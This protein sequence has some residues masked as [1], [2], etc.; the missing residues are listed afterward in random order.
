M[1]ILSR[2]PFFAVI[3]LFAAAASGQN[4]PPGLTLPASAS[5]GPPTYPCSRTDLRKAP[6]PDVIPSVGNLSGVNT[7]VTD[8][9]FQNPIVRVTDAY[10][11]PHSRNITFYSSAG[12]SSNANTWNKDSSLLFV[13]DTNGTGY[14]M[15]FD[16]SQMQVA[17]MY[18]ANFPKTGGMTVSSNHF[19]WSRVNP[20][21]LYVLGGTR[22][23]RY[24]FS[25]RNVP[26]SPQLIYDFAAS[27]HCLPAGFK[28]AW[29]N[30]GGVSANDGAFAFGLSSQGLQGTGN[31]AVVYTVGQGCTVLNTLTGDITS[32]WG[33]SGTMSTT[34]RFTLHDAYL[35]LDSGWAILGPTHCLSGK[36]ANGPY[37]WEV[38]TTNVTACGAGQQ[39]L[40]SGHW[41]LGY[42]HWANNDGDPFGQFHLRPF[43]NLNAFTPLINVLPLGFAPPIDQHPSWNNADPGD[44]TPF[45]SSSWTRNSPFTTAWQN[46]I[47]AISVGTGTVSRFAH[48]FITTRSHRFIDKEAI[49]QISQDGR[50]FIF[51]SDWMGTLG[52]ESGSSACTVGTDCRGDVFVVAAR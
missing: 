14:P 16:S 25:N 52:S 24:D 38:G 36:C 29:E 11:N 50:F 13:Q 9:D 26:P 48:T 21:Y 17:R 31:Y 41:T 27:P 45:F 43:S 8:P 28:P 1:R 39:Q 32:D 20:N 4:V 10:L 30:F 34:D 37:F 42:S 6:L 5:C 44:S 51:N 40:C 35:T 12:G 22:I 7:T 18:V 46:E 15:T 23:F 3:L 2:L 33:Q 19:S 47:I 49:G